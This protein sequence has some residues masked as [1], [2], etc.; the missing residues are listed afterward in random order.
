VKLREQTLSFLLTLL[1]KKEITPLDIATE[2][3]ACIDSDNERLNTYLEVYADDVTR[4]AKRLTHGGS[5]HRLPL[6][7][8]PIAVK[9]NIC[10]KGKKATCG[11]RMLEQYRSPYHATVVE[12]LL[13]AGAVI[14]GATNMDE[15]GM[16]SSTENSAFGP[17]NHPFAAGRVPGGS[18]GGSAAAVAAGIAP[19]ALGSDTGGSIRQ[20]AAFC[21]VVGMKPTYGRVSRYGLV[22][23]ASSFDQIGPLTKSVEDCALLMDVLCGHDEKDA[24]SLRQS[25]LNLR[26]VRSGGAEELA[27]AYPGDFIGQ[28]DHPDVRR[29][30]E[31]VV[32][33]LRAHNVRVSEV[34]LPHAAYAVACYTVIA[35]AEASANLARY[36]GVRYGYR[37]ENAGDLYDMYARTRSEGFGEEVK[38]RIL[39]G[40][41]VLSEGYRDAYYRKAQKVCSLLAEDFDEVFGKWDL[42]I[43]PTT[44]TPAFRLGEKVDDPLSM[45][46]SDVFTV[47]ANLA[48]LPA[49]SIPSGFSGDG[50]PLGVQLVGKRKHDEEVLKGAR[51]VERLIGPAARDGRKE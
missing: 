31:T 26:S 4:E 13:E 8:I 38:R 30:F 22:A 10:V 12:R 16:G 51:L 3:L 33:S 39:L 47:P 25:Q 11:S 36:D 32:A 41:F 50:L 48:G 43:T 7:G 18:S 15:F 49:V 20:P 9:N 40:T 17:T 37:A 2:L 5:F 21:G 45:Y 19:A 1:R 42:L 27:F 24:T 28:C 14:L 46:L 23:F 35:N 34:S 44:P 29:N 6:C